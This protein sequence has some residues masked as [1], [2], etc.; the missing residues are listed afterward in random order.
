WSIQAPEKWRREDRAG[1]S[2]RLTLGRHGSFFQPM[3]GDSTRAVAQSNQRDDRLPVDQV[4]FLGC[5]R[6]DAL[7]SS[8]RDAGKNLQRSRS[9]P[10]R[11]SWQ[12]CLG[13]R[14]WDCR[15]DTRMA[16]TAIRSTG[17]R[18]EKRKQDFAISCVKLESSR[19][20]VP[21]NCSL[22]TLTLPHFR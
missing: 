3:A 2:F 18:G 21:F 1:R 16:V 13:D 9:S 17:W 15:S 8:L 7:G 10:C 20:F 14:R 5:T 19:F 11:Y 22:S 12:P 6:R 4:L